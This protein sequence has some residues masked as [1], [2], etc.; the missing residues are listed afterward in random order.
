MNKKKIGL[1][2]LA[3]VLALGALGVGYAS[4]TDTIFVEGTVETGSVDIVVVD[5]SN[6]WIF[7]YPEHNVDVWHTWDSQEGE[8]E[9]LPGNP[10]P[11]YTPIAF[12]INYS[13][14]AYA[15]ADKI[16]DDTVKVV[17]GDAFP[18]DELRADMLV[19][20]VGSV[21]AIVDAEVTALTDNTDNGIDDCALLAQYVTVKFYQSDASGTQGTEIT[22]A[23]QMHECYYVLAIMTLNLPQAEDLAGTDLTQEDFMNLNCSFTAEIT[24]T[25]WNECN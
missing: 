2:A 6:T 18:C 8:V 11:D 24:A 25:Q 20:Y 4:W 17:F 1:L 13:L 21:P 3:L 10:W 5:T 16:A 19:H 12:P 15:D 9:P 14:I 22:E 23:Y 7:K